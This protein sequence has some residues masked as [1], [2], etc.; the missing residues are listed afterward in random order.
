MFLTGTCLPSC[1]DL[2]ARP[3]F[4]QR[5]LP[6]FH[7]NR[8]KAATLRSGRRLDKNLSSCWQPA[9]R[10]MKGRATIH[11]GA[12]T[13]ESQLSSCRA[14]ISSSCPPGTLFAPSA[15]GAHGI[16]SC[17]LSSESIVYSC[18]LRRTRASGLSVAGP[19]PVSPASLP[20]P[21]A[22]RTHWLD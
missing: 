21:T 15:T 6:P 3:S 7:P 16:H 10:P 4:G 8:R 13:I 9:V 22:S 17:D 12:G 2:A 1:D 11:A 18:T 14:A 19:D 5:R 20:P